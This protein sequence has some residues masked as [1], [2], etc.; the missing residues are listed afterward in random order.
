M[1]VYRLQLSQWELDAVLGWCF[2]AFQQPRIRFQLF[3][4]VLAGA[5]TYDMLGVLF[6]H[7]LL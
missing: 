5:K 4:N 1:E 2:G 6:K 3:T 7:P